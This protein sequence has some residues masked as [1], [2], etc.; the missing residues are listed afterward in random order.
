MKRALIQFDEELYKKLRKRA[1]EQHRSISSLVRELVSLNL[2]QETR[3]NVKH[4]RQLSFVASGRS[5]QEGLS[6]ISERHDEALA[7]LKK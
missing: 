4:A 6:P 7:R 1:Y 3:S 5:N 2:D